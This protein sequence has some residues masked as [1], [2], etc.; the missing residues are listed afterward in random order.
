MDVKCF[1]NGAAKKGQPAYSPK[2]T[3]S[4]KAA[5]N[6]ASI[7]HFLKGLFM[8]STQNNCILNRGK[9]G[10]ANEVL[11]N[12]VLKTISLKTMALKIMALKTMAIF[13]VN[14]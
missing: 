1:S 11:A 7:F 3:P 6:T 5:M 2:A 10:S 8:Q 13:T 4:I 14:T 9:R 12:S